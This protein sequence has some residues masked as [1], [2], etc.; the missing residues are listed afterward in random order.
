MTM[1]QSSVI[2]GTYIRLSNRLFNIF[3]GFSLTI[4]HAQQEQSLQKCTKPVKIEALAWRWSLH[5]LL[6]SSAT[7]L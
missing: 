3:A 1:S 2:S 7:S 4:R 5:S 6:S